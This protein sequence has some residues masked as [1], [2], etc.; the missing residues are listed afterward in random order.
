LTWKVFELEKWFLIHSMNQ[1]RIHQKIHFLASSIS[2]MRSNG[3]F[4]FLH[5]K[6]STIILSSYSIHTLYPALNSIT[7]QFLLLF[8][9]AAQAKKYH[10]RSFVLFMLSKI[11][12]YFSFSITWF[13][14]PRI[15]W[16]GYIY[17]RNESR[18]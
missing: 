13:F 14:I 7:N 15:I 2:S 5:Q 18:Q 11:F 12:F 16:K 10:K 1:L 17:M 3:I 8:W 6:S 9:Q 4:I